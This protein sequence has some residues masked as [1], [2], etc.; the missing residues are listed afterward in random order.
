MRFCTLLALAASAV[1]LF[2]CSGSAGRRGPEAPSSSRIASRLD[3]GDWEV[4]QDTKVWKVR[5]GQSLVNAP[6]R[7]I[8]YLVER[9]YRKVRGGPIFEM[10]TLTT[11]NRDEQIG[12]ID[13]LG[14]AVRYE[15]R[16][17]QGFE[18]VPVGVGTL[19]ESVGAIFDTPERITLDPTSQRR[20][21]FETLDENGDGVLTWQGTP[22]QPD[23][24]SRFGDRIP[25]ADS[26]RDG[27]VDFE[28][29][30]EIEI[31]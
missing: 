23:E 31:L 26:N 17:N 15:P 9:R 29:F 28:E 10:Y 3:R 6:P 20:I 27:A 2:A 14:R 30:D 19:E 22:E 21:T 4:A 5:V 25:A 24:I 16:R 11:L 18:E 7:H 8:G 1:T 13:S 12:H